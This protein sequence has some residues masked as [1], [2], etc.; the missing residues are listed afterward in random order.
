M[1]AA[2]RIVFLGE[3]EQRADAVARL[4]APGQAV[5]VQRGVP[6]ALVISCPCGCGE[7]FPINLDPRAGP[8]WR[9]Y[10]RGNRISLF[11]SVWRKGGCNAHYI[12]WHDF[13]MMIGERDGP[14][15]PE[16]QGEAIASLATTVLARLASNRWV[17]FAELADALDEVPWDVSKACRRLV[18]QGLATEGSGVNRGRFRRV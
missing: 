6:R 14:S 7:K 11:P 9:L 1:T 17:S 12:V 5:L 16:P 4:N 2:N 10:R 18:R 8:A 15:Q 3:V 13:I